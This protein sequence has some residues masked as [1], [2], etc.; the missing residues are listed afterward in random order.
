[1]AMMTSTRKQHSVVLQQ[2]LMRLG[3]D[4]NHYVSITTFNEKV[5]VHIRVFLPSKTEEGKM[6]PMLSGVALTTNEWNNLM[7]HAGIR[8]DDQ[9]VQLKEKGSQTN[10]R[11]RF[12]PVRVADDGDHLISVSLKKGRINVHLMMH[13]I[14]ATKLIE[15]EWNYLK[16]LCFSV[17]L[18]IFQTHMKL[19]ERR[20]IQFLERWGHSFPMITTETNKLN[21]SELLSSPPR[22]VWLNKNEQEI[23]NP[24]I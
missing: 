23:D 3:Q 6:I 15:C 19:N 20:T 16:T 1:M 5:Y 12:Q 13:N 14:T 21:K 8:I 22:V 10:F 7:N 2:D 9:I 18:K 24:N 17:Q 4:S 11:N